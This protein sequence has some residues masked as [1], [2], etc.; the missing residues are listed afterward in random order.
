MLPCRASLLQNDG[1]VSLA[2]FFSLPRFARQLTVP[3]C[4]FASSLVGANDVLP[5]LEARISDA[6]D[7]LET[8]GA[9]LERLAELGNL[10]EESGD[11]ANASRYLEQAHQ[12]SG[13]TAAVIA[14]LA[15]VFVKSGRA[16]EALALLK[17]G[18][19]S[20]PGSGEIYYAQGNVYLALKK[21][22]A[23]TYAFQKAAKA[24]PANQK[25]NYKLAELM[26]RRGNLERAEEILAPI[27]A[28]EEPLDDAILLYGQILFT[29]D[30]ERQGIRLVEKLLKRDKES[31]KVRGALVTMLLKSSMAEAEAGRI[32]RAVNLLED[33]NEIVPREPEILMGL[34]LLENEQGNP[35]KAIEHCNSILEAYPEDLQAYAFLGRMQRVEGL[36]EEAEATFKKG[37][38]LAAK[39]NDREQV[40][41]FERLLNPFE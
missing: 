14:D 25:Y 38:E 8:E 37:L 40:A 22:P 18:L 21:A 33:A 9:N 29:S 17:S 34:A 30:R 32:S 19:L 10:Y 13:V 20:F 12:E 11:L 35:A 6:L 15:R 2:S 3:A 28:L 5:A 31:D 26:F 39:Q 7:A 27:V 4:L 1:I 23:A 24:E 16:E 36:A 41:A